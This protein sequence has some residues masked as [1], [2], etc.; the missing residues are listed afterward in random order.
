VKSSSA[1]NEEYRRIYRDAVQPF[2]SEPVIAIGVFNRPGGIGRIG[3]AKVSPLASMLMG[4]SAKKK[5]GGLPTTVIVAVTA[6]KVHVFSY[7][8]ARS[9]P[10]I[11]EEVA[12]WDRRGLTVRT[13]PTMTATRLLL[14]LPDG[15]SIEL[16]WLKAGGDFN[17]EA[18]ETLSQPV[19]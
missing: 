6:D 18:V 1:R 17:D 5:S 13:E 2:V 14:G 12:T 7:K 3:V 16:E 11:E 10:K 4:R 9:T 8:P 15:E 19:R